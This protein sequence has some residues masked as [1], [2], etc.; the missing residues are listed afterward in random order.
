VVLL[1]PSSLPS[2]LPPTLLLSLPPFLLSN[3][4]Y[5]QSE[6]EASSVLFGELFRPGDAGLREEGREGGGERE[7]RGGREGGREGGRTE[8]NESCR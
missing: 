5:D 7:R 3:L 4:V 8:G 6:A 2:S 1:A